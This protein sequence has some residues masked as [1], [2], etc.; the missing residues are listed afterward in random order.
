MK[1]IGYFAS[2]S[3]LFMEAIRTKSYA[4][5]FA[6]DAY[7]ALREH[8]ENT[9]YSQ[10]FLLTDSNT[11]RHCYPAFFR[12]FPEA[13]TWTQ[14]SI[15]AGEKH[16][17]IESC[18]YAWR[19]LSEAGGDR[20]SLLVNLGGGVVTDLGGF[21]ASTYQ[22]GIDFINIPTTLLAM[23]DASVGGKTGVDLDTLKNQ[24]GVINQPVMVL[25]DTGYLAT[26]DGRELRSG[27][28]EMLKH[29]LITDASYWDELAQIRPRQVTEQHIYRSV[30]LK[31]K[32]VL[33][34]PSEQNL[35]KILNFGHTLGHAIESC[36][37]NAKT[38]EPLLH[39]EAIA[40]GMILEAHLSV[41][42]C[43][44]PKRDCDAIKAAFLDVFPR[45][46]ITPQ[47]LQEI[48]S[49]MLHDKKNA[50]GRIYFSLLA[51]IGKACYDQQVT[52]EQIA[53]SFD[54]YAY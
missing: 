14:L 9:R 54:Y 27:F 35:R 24:I 7:R 36:F 13:A 52:P 5:Y 30:Q 18:L 53:Q 23:V 2:R 28:A 50:Y 46:S 17:N 47:Q 33:Q 4:V 31:N 42:V 11:A 40:I 48:G 8:L 20:K 41:S 25:I 43:G 1:K 12:A 19:R 51:G 45:V 49:L 6:S 22:R 10:V 29:G 34:D 16:K 3:R 44:L 15:S 37:L 39:G 32:V 38:A 26:L 21:V